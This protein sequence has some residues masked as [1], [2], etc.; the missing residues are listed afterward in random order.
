[1]PFKNDGKRVVIALARLDGR[2]LLTNP[3]GVAVGA[4]GGPPR[5]GA[6]AVGIHTQTIT[7]VGG[8]ATRL[9]TR[10]PVAE[11]LL[12]EDFADVLGRR[13]V[14]LTF[15]TPLLCQSRV[16]GPVVDIV[17]QVRATAPPTSPSSTR[18]STTTTASTRASAH[19][20]APG[21]CRPSRGRS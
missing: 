4:G 19:R 14:V 18:R 13:R 10:R 20:S 15:A 5:V 16:C 9:S 2:L 1:M 6:R 3:F 11:D 8:E 12:R 17:E 7:D 21:G